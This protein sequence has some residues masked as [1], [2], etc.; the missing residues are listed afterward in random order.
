MPVKPAFEW[1]QTNDHV[2][3]HVTI[4]GFKK[5]AVDVFV[6]DLFTKVNAPPTYLLALDL[7][8]PVD[9]EL[10]THFFDGDDSS[11][12]HVK[13]CKAEPGLI[14]EA[15][16]FTPDPVSGGKSA[17]KKALMERR[18]ESMRRAEELYNKKLEAR[19]KQRDTERRR[20]TEEQWEVEKRQ[21]QVIEQRFN[22]E[23][24]A[25]EED[26]HAWEEAIHKAEEAREERG[27]EAGSAMQARR[28]VVP[29]TPADLLG[30]NGTHEESE[31]A[32]TH[33]GTSEVPPVRGLATVNV[34]IDF[35]PKQFAMPTRSRGDEEH[36]R[37]SRYKPVSVEDSP[38]FWKERADALYK[39]R[40]WRDSANAYSESIKRDGVF[41]TCVMNRAACYLQLGEY[42]RAIEDCTLSLT[43][44]ANTPASE[45]T[46]ERYRALMTKLHARRG[47]AYCWNDELAKGLTD[48]K[49]AAAYR[50]PTTDEDVLVDVETIEKLMAERGIKGQDDAGGSGN[51]EEAQ[52]AAKM[53]EA[54]AFYYKNDH[55]AAAACYREILKV[56][57]Y[58]AQARSNLAATLLQQGQ[59]KEA[60]AECESVIQ[61][62][63]EVAEALNQPGALATNET[64]SDDDDEVEE[65]ARSSQGLR[66]E[67]GEDSEDASNG[68]AGNRDEMVRRRR[69]A[70]RKISES[71]G[72]VYLLLKAYVR[73]AAALCG[74]NDYRRAHAFLE[75]AIRITPYD[76]DL[77]DDCNRLAEKI[78]V[79][80]LVAA[81]TGAPA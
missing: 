29:R 13:L 51:G 4:K 54:S 67:P 3:L 58:H 64:D 71:S 56:N 9:P 32:K 28:T 60:L 59:F 42:K 1:E 38:M 79:D 62:C 73:S 75:H 5:D 2:L 19:G 63:S 66:L 57:P 26:L 76:N 20:M 77:L 7:L 15:L 33:T 34:S 44:L 21:R 8:H 10:S 35:T 45:I 17:E 49:M 69:A 41:L 14:W 16:C 24:T 52:A 18:A 50:D 40:E 25:A 22:A 61:F 36:Y 55:E 12:L 72:H 47:A 43:M 23:K 80:T 27:S 48:L 30:V 11:V 6:S 39:T 68:E 78:R 37:Q 46:Q 53:Q 74:L 70:A 65:P 31:V 81:S